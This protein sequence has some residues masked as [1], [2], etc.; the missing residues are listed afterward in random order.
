M[1]WI[2]APVV[3]FSRTD[4][5]MLSLAAVGAGLLALFAASAFFLRPTRAEQAFLR[6]GAW[7]PFALAAGAGCVCLALSIAAQA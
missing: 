4:A 6:T 3:L 1:P 2:L 5:W 7:G